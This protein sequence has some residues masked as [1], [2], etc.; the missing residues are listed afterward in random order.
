MQEPN[1]K[2][3]AQTNSAKGLDSQSL[4]ISSP[5]FS[6]QWSKSLRMVPALTLRGVQDAPDEKDGAGLD[7]A[8]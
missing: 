1:L 3:R 5:S 4:K 2:S 6:G 7:I 8:D